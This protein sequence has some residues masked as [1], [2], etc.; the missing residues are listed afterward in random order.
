[1]RIK[2]SSSPSYTTLHF[3]YCAWCNR[4]YYNSCNKEY[5]TLRHIQITNCKLLNNSNVS[6][7]LVSYLFYTLSVLLRKAK[8]EN[9]AEDISFIFRIKTNWNVYFSFIYSFLFNTFSQ[10]KEKE[11]QPITACLSNFCLKPLTH[12]SLSSIYTF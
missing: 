11:N 12:D 5:I 7:F 1:M 9:N 4:I 6:W 3:W 8:V 10:R 2:T